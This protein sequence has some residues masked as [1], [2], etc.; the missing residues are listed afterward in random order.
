MLYV[1]KQIP[2]IGMHQGSNRNYTQM[3]RNFFVDQILKKWS[4]FM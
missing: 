4:T 1:V 2:Q 3:K